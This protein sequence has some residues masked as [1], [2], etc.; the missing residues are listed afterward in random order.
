MPV[1]R[2][3]ASGDSEW[4]IQLVHVLLEQTDLRIMLSNK[5]DKVVFRAN[6][7]KNW[8]FSFDITR[9]AYEN[10]EDRVP[11]N[12]Q[13]NALCRQHG[14]ITVQRGDTLFLSR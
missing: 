1:I 4:W 2:L 11:E 8:H 10:V 13:F 6:D 14:T 7:G 9:Q 3:M 5:R 12:F